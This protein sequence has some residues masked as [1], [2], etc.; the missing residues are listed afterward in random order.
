MLKQLQTQGPDEATL[1]KLVPK[2]L[3]FVLIMVRHE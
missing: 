3:T 1:L 2:S